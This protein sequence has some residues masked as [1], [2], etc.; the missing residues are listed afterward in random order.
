VPAATI[1]APTHNFSGGSW[2]TDGKRIVM[3]VSEKP[4]AM[5]ETEVLM[6]ERFLD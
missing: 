5:D 4:V 1:D 6:W 3:F 2:F